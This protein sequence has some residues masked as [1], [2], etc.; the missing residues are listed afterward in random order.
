MNDVD[1][2]AD[3]ARVV[4]T[5]LAGTIF[6]WNVRTHVLE[7]SI[8]HHD[9]LISIRLSPDGRQIATGDLKG[10]LDLWDVA[11]GAHL[12]TLG[13]QNGYVGS[14]TWSPDGRDLMTTS[15]DGKFRIW[16][17]ATRKLV[18]APLPGDAVGGWGTY[19]PNGK[20]IVAAF[21]TGKGVVWNVDPAAWNRAACRIAH[22][23]LTRAEWHQ[24]LPE[25]RYASV[26]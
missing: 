19:F 13:G 18:G 23:N 4:A 7:R 15:T 16:D 2:S 24:F 10:N 9:A 8:V 1:F 25:R 26:C 11:S 20:E 22:R 6:V 17:V 14:V 12:G 5:G 21:G 3:G